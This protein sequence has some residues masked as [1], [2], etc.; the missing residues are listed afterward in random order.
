MSS[1]KSSQASTK[2]TAHQSSHNPFARALAEIE[3]QAGQEDFSSSDKFDN[4]S[5]PTSIFDA[6]QNKKSGHVDTDSDKE[7]LN[8]DKLGKTQAEKVKYEQMRRKRHQEINPLETVDYQRIK[9][10]D[11]ARINEVRIELKKLAEELSKF[12]QE[13]DITLTQEVVATGV[14]A[15]YHDNFFAKLKEL[16]MML[17][18]R[19]SSARTWARQAKA[20]QRKRASR[21]STGLDFNSNEAKAAHDVFHHERSSAYGA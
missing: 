7:L 13:V 10:R 19:V 8:F 2:R 12:Y 6:S 18:Q 1:S 20:K 21:F 9:E 3:K 4:V 16:I 5:S 15:I 14:G 11:N 17:R